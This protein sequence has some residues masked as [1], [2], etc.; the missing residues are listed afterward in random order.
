MITAHPPDDSTVTL[1]ELRAFA[2]RLFWGFP[3][4]G[5]L[6]TGLNRLFSEEWTVEILYGF[7]LVGWTLALP[8]ALSVR[9]G[10][11]VRAG[12]RAVM[13][14]LE[15]NVTRLS[16]FA[17]F[18]FAI[19]P[20]GLFR[21]LTGKDP[22]LRRAPARTPATGYRTHTSKNTTIENCHEQF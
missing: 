12:C 9:L 18:C 11:P 8:C 17:A 2:F 13:S 1:E 14:F 20:F 7:L 19:L 5:C 21:R 6:W 3:L 15:R 10:S 22:L 4:A 16:L